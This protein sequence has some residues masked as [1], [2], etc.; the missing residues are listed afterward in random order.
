MDWVTQ[1]GYHGLDNTGWMSSS[2][3]ATIIRSIAKPT[4]ATSQTEADQE[5]QFRTMALALI[6]WVDAAMGSLTFAFFRR[7]WRIKVSKLMMGV[8]GFRLISLS[9]YNFVKNISESH[10]LNIGKYIATVP[11]TISYY[12]QQGQHNKFEACSKY[13]RNIVS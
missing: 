2:N 10:E 3:F 8:L 6:T 13:L 11:D 1:V 12:L 5:R 9:K 4:Q 7:N